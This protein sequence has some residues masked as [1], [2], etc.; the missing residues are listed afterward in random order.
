MSLPQRGAWQGAFAELSYF[1]SE[2]VEHF[3][4][5]RALCAEMQGGA[6]GLV[7]AV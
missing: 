6:Y 2:S 5:C 4:S 1:R 7:R 3:G